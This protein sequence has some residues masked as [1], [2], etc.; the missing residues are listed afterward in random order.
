MKL[1][2]IHPVPYIDPGFAAATEAYLREAVLPDTELEFMYVEKGY[3]SIETA[4][5]DIVNG[6]EIVKAVMDLQEDGCD[7]IFIN[8]FDDPALIA[9]REV[10]KKP[11]LGPYGSAVSLAGLLGEKVGIITTDEYGITCEERKARDYGFEGRIAA[12][13]PVDLTVL[14][15]QDKELIRRIVKCCLEFEKERVTTVVLGCT[16]MN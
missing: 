2:V 9:A 3:L 10:S 15:L 5:Q 11:V 1:K 8:C 14:N 4:A 7:G 6:A 13:K 16:G 12:I